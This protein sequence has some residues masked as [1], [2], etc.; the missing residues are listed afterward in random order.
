MGYY[1]IVI[2]EA[3]AIFFCVGKSNC[4]KLQ[5]APAPT[6]RIKQD[7]LFTVLKTTKRVAGQ[8]ADAYLVNT[9]KTLHPSHFER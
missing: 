3:K 7:S 6:K 2:K 9:L 5:S 4:Y 8:I 1:H